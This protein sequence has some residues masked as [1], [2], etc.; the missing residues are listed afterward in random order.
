M[1]RQPDSQKYYLRKKARSNYCNDSTVIISP[2]PMFWVSAAEHIRYPGNH[3]NDTTYPQT[4][5]KT[6]CDSRYSRELKTDTKATL[7]TTK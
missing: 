3:P 1:T 5:T 4:Y 7:A 2:N 6:Q